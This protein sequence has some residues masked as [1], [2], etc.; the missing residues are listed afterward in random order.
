MPADAATIASV[1]TALEKL[2]RDYVARALSCRRRAA[3]RGVTLEAYRAGTLPDADH[4]LV[5]EGG[6]HEL[7]ITRIGELLRELRRGQ[8]P[9]F[10]GYT[11]ANGI[12][13]ILAPL[14]PAPSP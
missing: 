14:L 1:I 7:T 13:A 2:R 4:H 11:D 6:D 12:D 10:G 8:L 3:R 9:L 5:R